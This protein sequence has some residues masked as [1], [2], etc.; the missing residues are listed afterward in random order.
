[1]LVLT[2]FGAW[3]EEKEESLRAYKPSS[4]ELGIK[5]ICVAI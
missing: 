5:K 4:Q 3:F 1:M 2:F